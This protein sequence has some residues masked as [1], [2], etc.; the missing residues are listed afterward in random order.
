MSS[1]LE[2]RPITIGWHRRQLEFEIVKAFVDFLN[3]ISEYCRIY[4][5]L[6]EFVLAGT[7]V[8]HQY[9]WRSMFLEG[10]VTL[11]WDIWEVMISLSDWSN[12]NLVALFIVDNWLNWYH[13]FSYIISS[14]GNDIEVLIVDVQPVFDNISCVRR[15]ARSANKQVDH[16]Y[17]LY[18]AYQI[19]ISCIRLSDVVRYIV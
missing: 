9:L 10:K 3:N 19:N 17:Q 16:C 12:L 4:P 15:K 8:V 6:V 5:Q 11:F 14:S 13:D 1:K 2:N 7:I 18:Q